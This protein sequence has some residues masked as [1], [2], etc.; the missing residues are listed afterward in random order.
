M[1]SPKPAPKPAPSKV[2]TSWIEKK[3]LDMYPGQT[4][5][6][7]QKDAIEHAIGIPGSLTTAILPTGLGKTRI[8]QALTIS[9]TRGHGDRRSSEGPV[10][11]V[12]PTIS[13]M[14]D[15]KREWEQDLKEDMIKA[16]LDPLRVRVIHSGMEEEDV[17]EIDALLIR[18]ELDA[19]LCSPERL[20]PKRN[21]IGMM[22]VAARLG[23]SSKGN[24]FSALIIDETHIIYDWGE[25]I[26]PAFHL[27]PQ[28][29]STL[30]E[31][32]PNL[33]TLL[34]TA[35][36]T[37]REEEDLIRRLDEHIRPVKSVRRPTVRK[38][39]AFTIIKKGFSDVPPLAVEVWDEYM[40]MA[41]LR[42]CRL[43]MG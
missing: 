15:Q 26:R 4:L 21:N 16:G 7:E 19:V 11:I 36:L 32:N 18:G 25:S 43:T 37:P 35:T 13:L 31:I 14:D 28:I 42:L 12:Y 22:G 27:I 34:M 24:P 33:R 8:A 1:V 9:L 10:L 6:P 17:D 20:A 5:Y 30:R 29:D 40:G 38:D 3:L 2:D 39:L 23:G 41:T